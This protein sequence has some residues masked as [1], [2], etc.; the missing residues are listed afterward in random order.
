[1]EGGNVGTTGIIK[2]LESLIQLALQNALAA[3][4]SELGILGILANHIQA[5]NTAGAVPAIAASPITIELGVANMG[6]PASFTSKSQKV[7][8]TVV[9]ALAASAVDTELVLQP[10]MDGVAIAGF[11]VFRTSVGHVSDGT[12][13]TITYDQTTDLLAHTWGAIVTAGAGTVSASQGGAIIKVQD[14]F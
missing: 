10:S 1:M 7:R 6:N 9:L 12:T 13:V 2:R 11:A 5:V 3:I 14:L 4:G 8:V